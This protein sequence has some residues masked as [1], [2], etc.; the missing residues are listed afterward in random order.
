M[1]YLA[2]ASIL[3]AVVGAAV[4]AVANAARLPYA[5]FKVSFSGTQ[6]THV[7][8]SEDCS[9]AGG[10]MAPATATETATF[11]SA[12]SRVFQFE[13]AGGELN[14]SPAKGYGESTMA[15][16]AALDAT[17]QFAQD[18]GASPVCGGGAPSSSCGH[19]NLSLKMLVQGGLNQVSFA[20]DDFKGFEPALCPM[21]MAFAFPNVLPPK[22]Y[23]NH[24]KI[25]YSASTSRGLLNPRKHVVIVHGSATATN[26]GQVADMHV[27]SAVSTLKFTM[28]LVRVPLR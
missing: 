10:G 12:K 19:A 24:S 6:T 27:S 21:P 28:R 14:I 23:E 7:T 11:K 20:V 17:S 1:R 16:K 25:K 3:A 18:G 2:V 22:D 4:P 5:N 13:R 26:S 9:D 8:G 15:V